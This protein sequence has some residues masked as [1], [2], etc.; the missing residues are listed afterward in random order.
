M[1]KTTPDILE[2]RACLRMGVAGGYTPAAL[3]QLTQALS[4]ATLSEGGSVLVAGAGGGH[5]ADLAL[6]DIH[7]PMQQ[8]GYARQRCGAYRLR[9]TVWLC[10]GCDTDGTTRR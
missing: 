10:A 7:L 8:S 9:T 6:Q 4:Y 3:M 1:E 5:W 2:L